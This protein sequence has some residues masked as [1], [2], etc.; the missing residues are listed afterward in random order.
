MQIP[1]INIKH[2]LYATDHSENAQ[3]A[4][5]YAAS[6][7]DR[8]GAKLTLLHVMPEFPDSSIFDMNIERSVSAKKWLTIKK[9]YLQSAKEE[10]ISKTRADFGRDVNDNYDIVVETG[11]PS[12]MIMLVAAERQCDFIVMGLK[13]KGT[14][15]DPLMGDTVRRVLHQSKQP[16]LVVQPP[17]P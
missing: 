15:T 13:G 3:F 4:F 2:V 11:S 14:L 9:E 1:D 12:Q 8:Y 7:A 17:T 10:L 16:V 5:A 6:I